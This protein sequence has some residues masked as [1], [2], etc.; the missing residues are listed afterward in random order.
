M[1]TLHEVTLADGRRW[2]GGAANHASA[3]RAAL[4]E[5]YPENAPKRME[6]TVEALDGGAV[7]MP[8]VADVTDE[9]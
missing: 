1:S 9:S 8:P 3:V 4:N 2:I 5:L 6:L 7:I